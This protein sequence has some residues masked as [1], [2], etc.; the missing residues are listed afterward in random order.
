MQIV[1]EI[2]PNR[3]GPEASGAG[4]Q[5]GTSRLERLSIAHAEETPT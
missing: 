1:I 2:L 5:Q 4:D 3:D